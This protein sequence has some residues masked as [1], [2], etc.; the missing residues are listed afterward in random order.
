MLTADDLERALAEA[1]VAAAPVR[2]DEVTGS[3]NATA[4]ELA[5]ADSPEW[6][7]VSAGHQIAGRGRLGRAWQDGPGE[8]LLCSFVLRPALDP[9]AAG[10]LTL[11]AGASLAEAARSLGAEA[12]CKWPNDLMTPDG[13]AGG[14]LAEAV[15]AG[16]TLRHVVIGTGV[17]LG[18]FPSSVPGAAALPDVAPVPLLGRYLAAF[19]RRYAPGE[20]GFADEVLAAAR[21]VSVTLGREV[22]AVRADG[23]TVTG[24]AV[25]LDAEGGLVVDTARGPATLA[26]GEVVHVRR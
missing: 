6:T 25:D 15:V 19:A 20:V 14:I 2:A 26:F 18:A 16:R 1:G 12:G 17:N 13:K 3:T 10:L 9:S 7:L 4:L 5:E 8:A 21:A 11:L 22:E 24:T 23:E